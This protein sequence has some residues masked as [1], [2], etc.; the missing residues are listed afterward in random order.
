MQQ[1]LDALL[2]WLAKFRQRA[3]LAWLLVLVNLGGVAYGF[4]YYGAQFGVTPWYLWPFVPDSPLSTGFFA[5]A[6]ALHQL[7]RGSRLVDWLAFVANVK[8]GLWTGYV[9]LHYDAQFGIFVQPLTNLNFWLFWLHLA[10]AAQAFVLATSLRPGRG[11]LAANA[12]FAADILMDYAYPGFAYGGCIGTKPITVPCSDHELLLGV[13]VALWLLA[14]GTGAW[15]ARRNG[16]GRGG[17]AP[18]QA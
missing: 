6:L 13:T 1:R 12:F 8:V 2:A 3:G 11:M 18:T 15:L 5:L 16:P 7:R 17:L 14:L 10:M 9:L 4:L